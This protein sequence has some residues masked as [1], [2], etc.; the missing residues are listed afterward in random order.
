MVAHPAS[1]LGGF[2]PVEPPRVAV[3]ADGSV[4]LV[5]EPSRVTI[6]EI[7]SGAAFAEI[8]VDPEAAASE[9]AWLGS[10]QRLLVLSRYAAHSTAHLLDPYG[11]R[12]ISEI[13]LESPMRL[14]ATVGTAGLVVGSLGAAVLVAG[15]SHL[16]PY[17][18]PTRAVPLAAGAA[19][20]QF[21]VALSGSIEEWDPQSRM[22]K[23]RLRLPR[24]AAITA[25]G[26]S[27]RLVWMITQQEPA[28]IDVIPLVN[29]GQPKAHDLPEPIASIASQPRSDI[30]ACIGA[31]TGRLYVVDLDGRTRLRSFD[32]EGLDRIDSIGLIV[33]RMV[34]VLAAQAHRPIVLVPLDGREIDP[35]AAAAAR[36]PADAAGPRPPGRAAFAGAD[37][38]GDAETA[39]P[40][41]GST[42]GAAAAPEPAAPA[43]TAPP[44]PSPSPSPAPAF[45]APPFAA[46]PFA[47]V[48]AAWPVARM[49]APTAAPATIAAPAP[50]AAPAAL[51]RHAAQP[52]P[53]R[54]APAA[55]ARTMPAVGAR[56]SAWRDVRQQQSSPELAAAP[57]RGSASE[58]ASLPSW[59]DE[60]VAWSRAITAGALDPG[61]P[62]APAIDAAMARFDLAPALQ[63]VL[64]L[65]YGAHLCGELGAAPV[66]VARLLDHQ[67]DEALGRGELADRG[68]ATYAGSRVALSP[69]LLRVFDELPPLTGTLVG[70]PG[71]VA[72]LGP[73]VVVA[74]DEPLTAVAERCLARING[75]ILVAHDAPDR[76]A[77]VIEARARGAAAMLRA[78]L[79]APPAE[80]AIFVLDDLELAERLG[81]PRLA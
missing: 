77:L 3:A 67:W 56:F 68:V 76:R 72:L 71:P 19:A 13:R 51:F 69:L 20:G 52:A 31:E 2:T 74:G 4:A 36:A 66:D 35:E 50:T 80:A 18:F 47:R 15:E 8:G 16:T 11:P 73:C 22:P 6:L 38:D 12:T 33:G 49:A 10:P 57:A 44:S 48:A 17:Q 43:V 60:I 25:V 78:A 53:P 23:R 37:R 42:L 26:G 9:V 39:V 55:P 7:P 75:A 65:L 29:R 79:A 41:A 59:R 1:R 64:W 61:V 30:V 70:E 54:P 14:Y 46:P 45:A 32:P 21:V 5:H 40:A 63:P 28:R 27:D 62:V 58:R 34:A 81:L 24:V